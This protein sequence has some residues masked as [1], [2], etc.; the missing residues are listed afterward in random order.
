MATTH[1]ALMRKGGRMAN[2]E[3]ILQFEAQRPAMQGSGCER[4]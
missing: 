2:A 3:Q 1:I 4:L